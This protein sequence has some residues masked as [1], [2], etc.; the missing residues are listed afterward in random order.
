MVFKKTLRKKATV[1]RTHELYR[2]KLF[3][4]FKEDITL[5]NGRRTEI[6]TV[7]HPGSTGIVPLFDDGTIAMVSQYR[8]PIGDYLLE[9][10]AGTIE[11]GESP[12]NCARREL[13]E[14]VGLVA[15]EFIEV[16][17]IYIVPAYSDERIHVYL[18]KDLAESKQNLDQDEII[19]VVKYPLNEVMQMIGQGII[20]DALTILALQHTWRYIR[21]EDTF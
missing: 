17:Q 9:I 11:H 6:A 8:H 4:F 3:S 20:T 12:L 15:Q 13:E 18:A 19:H 1:N 16:A 2:G 10:P 7:R 14:E 5:P 21:N